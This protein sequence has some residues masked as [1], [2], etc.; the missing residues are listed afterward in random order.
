MKCGE[1]SPWNCFHNIIFS[2]L[3]M[4]G[5]NK[6]KHSVRLDNLARDKDSNLVGRIISYEENAVFVNTAPEMYLNLPW[7]QLPCM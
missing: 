5:R 3:L 2:L 6:L 1:Y 4:N 7:L